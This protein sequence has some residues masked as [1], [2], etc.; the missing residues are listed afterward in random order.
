MDDGVCVY[1]HPNR[2][3]NIRRERER[4]AKILVAEH[5]TDGD[6]GSQVMTNNEQGIE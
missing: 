6:K 4:D 5:G 1:V 2:H 3:R